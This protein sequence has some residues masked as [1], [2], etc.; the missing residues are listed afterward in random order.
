MRRRLRVFMRSYTGRLLLGGLLIHALL[1]PIL[2]FALLTYETKD[3][4]EQ[5]VAQV[6]ERTYLLWP[7][8]DTRRSAEAIARW[9]DEL[10]LSGQAD[11]AEYVLAS[12]DT[13]PSSLNGRS[14]RFQEDL[15]FGEHGD[16]MYYVASP[17]N[18]DGGRLRLGFSELAVEEELQR[19][20]QFSLA[21]MA[22]YLF[23]ASLLI[24]FFG[25]RLTDAILRLQAATRRIANGGIDEPMIVDTSVSEISSLATDLEQMRQTLVRREHEMAQREARQRAVLETAAEGIVTVNPEGRIESFNRAAETLFGYTAAEAMGASFTRFLAPE[26]AGR[27][28]TP[29][30]E[31]AV[32]SGAE[33][34]GRRRSGQKCQLMLSVS[35]AVAVDSRCF[36]IFIQDISERLAYEAQLAHQATHDTLTGLPNRALYHDRLTQVLAHAHREE[37]IVG[38]FFLDLDRFKYINDSLGHHI[39]D[40]LL[41]AVSKRLKHC[42]RTEDT[43]ARLGGDEFTIILPHLERPTNSV[44]VAENIV[45]TLEKP[46]HIGG[47]E[48]FI[49]CSIGIAFFPFDG[50]EAA[51]LSKN[52]DTAMYATKNLGGHGF[53]FYSK[54]MNATAASRLE[55]DSSLRYALE[56]GELLLHYQPQVD[57][58]SLKIVGVEALLRWQHPER[59]LVPPWEFIP[60]AEETGV[61]IPISEWVLETAC[62]QGRAW[63]DEGLPISVGVNLSACHFK[64][65][66][67]FQNIRDTLSKTGFQPRL[68]DLELTE[69]M[70]MEHCDETVAILHQ[71]KQLGVTLSLDDFGTGYSS[72]SYLK[73]FPID[74]LKIDRSFIQDIGEGEQ[75]GTLATTIIAMARSLRMQVIAEGVE[76]DGHLAYL[77]HHRCD[78][79]QG[80]YFSKPLPADELTALLRRHLQPESPALQLMGDA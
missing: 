55:L 53:Q 47:K 68:L 70:V 37:H 38:L 10:I 13:M 66:N 35:E 39:G 18:A 64:E 26:E 20:V 5:F 61:I 78:I 69:S 19:N 22:A 43:L 76:T 50:K 57:V 67:L 59:G 6:R 9:G 8:L 28:Y 41:V 32:C 36:T 48:L 80:F 11:Y 75:D 12:G 77:R 7:G 4:K 17:P 72:L 16:H 21:L 24:A 30:G 45:K 62:R 15:F 44:T 73:Q 3:H 52:A 63:Q 65:P 60:L 31:P 33:F 25:D 29:G 42:L 1:L 49:S 79:F 46:F 56:R 54:P 23:L 40:E 58:D 74:I 71:L 2:F 14:E 34:V 51:E 27:F